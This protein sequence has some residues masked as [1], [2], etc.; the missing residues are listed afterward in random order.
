MRN[1]RL[2]IEYDGTAYNGW[3]V[4][5]KEQRKRGGRVKT[6]QGI[7]ENA[8][9]KLFSKK[10]RIISYS[11]TDSGVHAK[12]HT[13]NFKIS[14]KLSPIR[15]KKALNSL[16]PGDI[17][18]KSAEEV[19][20]DFNARYHARSKTYRYIICNR[21]HMSP[22]IRNYAYHLRQP[23]G[24]ALMKK[25]AKALLGRHDFGAFRSSGAK[26]SK[27]VSSVRTVKKLEISKKK[28]L[29]AIEIEADGFLYNMARNI[30]GTL[31]EIGRGRFPTGSMRAILNSRDR[32][33]AGPTAPAKGL[34]LVDVRY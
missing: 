28:G 22:F 14:T 24:T 21:D 7:L 32:K 12:S 19:S 16:L 33:K 1:F 27:R 29:V 30:A 8:L 13:A 5:S 17:I 34:C 10:V 4:Q 26:R 11:R 18:V 23:L 6:L 31:I 9:F 15:I 3:Q 20:S 2:G 25:E